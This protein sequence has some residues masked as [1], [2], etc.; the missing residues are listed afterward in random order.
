MTSGMPRLFDLSA[1]ETLCILHYC[2]GS[3]GWFVF[4]A[5]IYKGILIGFS[6]PSVSL[7]LK[8]CRSAYQLGRPSENP[9]KIYDLENALQRPEQ[10]SLRR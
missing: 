6:V 10:T 1:I 4:E 7:A 5:R 8:Q 2:S 9:T 3:I